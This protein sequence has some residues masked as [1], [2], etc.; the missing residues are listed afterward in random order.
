MSEAGLDEIEAGSGG[1]V[2]KWRVHV[3][4]TVGNHI[5][6][7]AAAS[8]KAALPGPLVFQEKPGLWELT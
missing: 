5:L 1:A 6:A 4:S 8:C 7:S 2:A 3:P